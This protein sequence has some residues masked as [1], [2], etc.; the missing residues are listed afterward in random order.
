MMW[1]VV[2]H[3]QRVLDRQAVSLSGA[4]QSQAFSV[5]VCDRSGSPWWLVGGGGVAKKAG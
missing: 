1:G 5:S 3:G 2:T 4:L